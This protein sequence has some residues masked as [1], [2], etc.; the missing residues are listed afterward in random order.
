MLYGEKSLCSEI[1][2]KHVNGFREQN[3]DDLILHVVV[4]KVI[5]RLYVYISG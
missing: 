4:Y 3:I 2:T 1:H 5:A